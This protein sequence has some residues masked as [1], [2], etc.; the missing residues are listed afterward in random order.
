MVAD[1]LVT[2]PQFTDAITFPFE[3]WLSLPIALSTFAMRLDA[4]RLLNRHKEIGQGSY[5][6]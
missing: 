6:H 2:E 5:E 4:S 1:L 3:P